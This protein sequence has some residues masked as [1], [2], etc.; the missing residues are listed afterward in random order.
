[1]GFKDIMVQNYQLNNL[2][3]FS[4]FMFKLKKRKEFYKN[5]RRTYR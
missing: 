1:M 5:V 2:V 4:Y 3:Q